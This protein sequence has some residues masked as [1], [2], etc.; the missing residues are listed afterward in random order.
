[1][2]SQFIFKCLESWILNN[3]KKLN[4]KYDQSDR[5]RQYQG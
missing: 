1:M 4:L 3:I 2:I 5:I